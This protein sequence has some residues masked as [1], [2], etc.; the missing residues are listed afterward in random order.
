MIY[1]IQLLINWLRF[2]LNINAFTEIDDDGFR[3]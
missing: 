1:R 2:N 3:Q